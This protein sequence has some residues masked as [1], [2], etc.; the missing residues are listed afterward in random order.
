ME[1][2][3]YKH[4]LLQLVRYVVLGLLLRLG[5]CI[6]VYFDYKNWTFLWPK[7][8]VDDL[9]QSQNFPSFCLLTSLMSP[10]DSKCHLTD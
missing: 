3:W 9:F 1:F 8:A 10:K 5:V 2:A 6:D 4:S 7:T